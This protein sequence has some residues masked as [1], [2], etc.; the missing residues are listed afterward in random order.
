MPTKSRSNID[1][2][3]LRR[4]GRGLSTIRTRFG[5]SQLELARRV[6]THR[7]YIGALER[8]ETNPTLATLVKLA[9]GL[10]IP[11]ADL[12]TFDDFDDA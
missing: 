5:L 2:A 11:L 8:G 9:T 7:N 4:F 6:G 10:G 1:P 3:V 12:M